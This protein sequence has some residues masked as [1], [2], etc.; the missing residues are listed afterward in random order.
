MYERIGWHRV[1]MKEIFPSTCS[2]LLLFERCF[3]YH[4]LPFSNQKVSYISQVAGLKRF[5]FWQRVL[6]T[7]VSYAIA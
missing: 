1:L 4:D 2:A 7:S 6:K 3:F 5:F